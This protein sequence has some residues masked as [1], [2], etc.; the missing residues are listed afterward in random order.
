MLKKKIFE[1][2]SCNNELLSMPINSV[3]KQFVL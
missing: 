2:V 1:I 3:V